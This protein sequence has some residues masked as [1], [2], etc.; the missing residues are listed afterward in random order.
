MYLLYTDETS[1][2][3]A[4]AE[5]FAY[6]GVIIPGDTASALSARI[7]QIRE[8][9]NYGPND[10]LKF[11]TRDRPGHIT[12]AQHLEI[13]RAV[14][15]ASEQAHVKF[16][17]SVILHKLAT[18]METARRNEINRVCLSFNYELSECQDYGVVLLDSFSEPDL[19]AFLR[20]K[21]NR[22][23]VG[24]PYG[25]VRLDRIL[26][27]HLASIGSS[28]FT[29]VVDVILGAFRYLINAL[30]KPAQAEVS[31]VLADQLSPLMIRSPH[32]GNI[33]ERSIFFSPR[34]VRVPSYQ[35]KYTELCVFL[36]AQG[37]NRV[38]T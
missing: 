26:G 21:F 8:S 23:C 13:K 22:G 7:D 36:T 34:E 37:L 27:F 3:P 38:L 31:R 6:G 30:A 5:F 32:S 17:S 33:S 29:S 2:D 35:Q 20:E 4:N 18:N 28:N 14:M 24:M 9:F 19:P 12:P 10:E 25:T 15:A 11:N 1:I 16:L